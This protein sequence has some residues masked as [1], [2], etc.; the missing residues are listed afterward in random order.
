MLF[1]VIVIFYLCF[2]GIFG[3]GLICSLLFHNHVYLL[4]FG[5]LF[6]GVLWIFWSFNVLGVFVVILN[7][8]EIVLTWFRRFLDSAIGIMYNVRLI[9]KVFI[10]FGIFSTV[11]NMLSHLLGSFLYLDLNISELTHTFIMPTWPLLYLLNTSF[12]MV[13]A[14]FLGVYDILIEYID[15]V[16]NISFLGCRKLTPFS[17]QA[18][19]PLLSRLSQA[20]S[21]L[22]VDETWLFSENM[23]YFE[24]LLLWLLSYQ[25]KLSRYF[26]V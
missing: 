16:K 9:F 15:P 13:R 8:S 26:L 21:F 3:F 2:F 12:S 4:L 1:L 10:V 7:C 24:D 19:L 14:R 11:I 25:I 6:Q 18:I 23:S 17:V 20:D 22:F 5:D